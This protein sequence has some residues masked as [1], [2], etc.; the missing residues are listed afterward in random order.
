VS[1]GAG[2]MD[3]FLRSVE[4]RAYTTALVATRGGRDDA[5]DI[6]QDAMTAMFR[7]YAGHP[8]A[9]WGA[10]FHR[11]LHSRIADWHRRRALRARF[12]LPWFG[13]GRDEDG[14]EANAPELPAPDQDSPP[15]ALLAARR[16]QQFMQ[17]LQALPLR[18]Q[19][20]FMLRAWEGLDTAQTARAMGCS[21][22]SVKTHLSRAMQALRGVLE[23]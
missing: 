6:V 9:D 20:A 23:E 7:S 21:E 14:D 13:G 22:G 17:A 8:P 10:L 12:F 1:E 15:E 4:R 11:V 16:Q 3:A 2:N 18:Q 19:Q 5:L